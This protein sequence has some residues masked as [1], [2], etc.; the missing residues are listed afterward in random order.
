M[1][2]LKLLPVTLCGRNAVGRDVGS[3][4]AVVSLI[5]EGGCVDAMVTTEPLI[6]GDGCVVGKVSP[7]LLVVWNVDTLLTTGGL[8]PIVGDVKKSPETGEIWSIVVGVDVPLVV[9][10]DLSLVASVLQP[11]VSGLATLVEAVE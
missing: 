6:T 10:V 4:P 11:V 7:V 8:L 1:I 5:P 9:G 2:T 3:A